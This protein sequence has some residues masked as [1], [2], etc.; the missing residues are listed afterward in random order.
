MLEALFFIVSQALTHGLFICVSGCIVLSISFPIMGF[1][2]C[3]R[4]FCYRVPLGG[5]F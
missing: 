3:L 2:M 1:P 4:M 5:T